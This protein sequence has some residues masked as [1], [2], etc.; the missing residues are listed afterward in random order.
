MLTRNG[1]GR[2]HFICVWAKN[3]NNSKKCRLIQRKINVK[4]HRLHGGRTWITFWNPWGRIT[5]MPCCSDP[6]SSKTST[7]TPDIKRLQR[8]IERPY[9]SAIL[10][11]ATAHCEVCERPSV[12]PVWSSS[13]TALSLLSLPSRDPWWSTFMLKNTQGLLEFPMKSIF[14]HSG[15]RGHVFKFH[16]RRR[17]VPFFG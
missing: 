10:V 8:R 9:Y 14:T 15:L 3:E 2:N 16:Q 5:K 11:G 4:F 13:Q 17:A 12:F 1:G 6:R 7:L